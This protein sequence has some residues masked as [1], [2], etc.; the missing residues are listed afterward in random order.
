MTYGQK[1]MSMRGNN[2]HFARATVFHELF[3]GHG[4]QAFM[5]ARYRPY[6]A[7]FG[8]PFTGEGWALY[9]EMLLWDLK[10]HGLPEDR[11]GAL[12]WRMHR[13]ARI[14]FSLG[15]HLGELTPQQCVDYLVDRVGH[16]R[17]NAIGEVRR[18][19]ATT[20]SP[21][22][23]AAYLLGGLQFYALRKELVDTGRLTNRQFHDAI[24]KLNRIPVEMIRAS[25]TNQ[26][27]TRDFSSNWKF[28]GP[29][30]PE[31]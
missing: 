6:R 3:P 27:L 8:T 21:L 29:V 26:K 11:I 17:D 13:C 31:K 16:E 12:F 5:G 2:I 10:F 19:F 4:L 25:L 23:Q 9:W 24:L 22:Y 15:F 28:Y 1:L 30:A 20:Y 7:V 14:V 18:S